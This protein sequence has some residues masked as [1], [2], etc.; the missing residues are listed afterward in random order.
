MVKIVVAFTIAGF[1]VIG[2][3]GC[4][5]PPAGDCAELTAPDAVAT[6]EQILGF[7][8]AR[9]WQGVEAVRLSTV[10]SEG[11]F[12]LAV[13]PSGHAVY[14]SSAFELPP[15]TVRQLERARAI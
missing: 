10:H 1:A 4:S 5:P 13:R 14:R 9:T 7:E 3:P 8:D 12:S 15:S 6:R 2:S 11:A